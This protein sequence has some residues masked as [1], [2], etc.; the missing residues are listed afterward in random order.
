MR[1]GLY[2]F[3]SADHQLV[4]SSILLFSCICCNNV[5]GIF[6]FCCSAMRWFFGGICNP[7][8]NREWN[9]HHKTL[10]STFC[11]VYSQRGHTVVL[12]WRN[13]ILVEFWRQHFGAF[14]TPYI[15]VTRSWTNK[16]TNTLH[17]VLLSDKIGLEHLLCR[18]SDRPF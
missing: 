17:E 18:A 7:A 5:S 10:R 16:E 13:T 2:L 15:A 1:V 11:G 12:P 14:F 6:T 8:C 9:L 4:A 3:A